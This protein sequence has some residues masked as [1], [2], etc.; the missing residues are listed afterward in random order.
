MHMTPK[1]LW[2]SAYSFP[3]TSHTLDP[4]PRSM[5]TGHGSFSWNEE[6]TPPGITLTARS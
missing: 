5:Y 2:K 3:S 4:A 1:P 6:G